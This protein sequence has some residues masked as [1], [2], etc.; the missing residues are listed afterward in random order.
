MNKEETLLREFWERNI[1]YGYGVNYQEFRDLCMR[2]RNLASRYGIKL[3]LLDSA[4]LITQF[5]IAA[6]SW[7][8]EY[9]MDAVEEYLSFIYEEKTALENLKELLEKGNIQDVKNR[10]E[11]LSK[12]VQLLLAKASRHG[13]FLGTVREQILRLHRELEEIKEITASLSKR[14]I[15]I[16]EELLKP[17]CPKCGSEDYEILD[18]IYFKESTS[19]ALRCKRCGYKYAWQVPR[20]YELHQS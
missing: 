6:G 19:Y 9:I 12:E 7:Q 18:V 8:P 4:K 17:I 10:I 20:G 3:S 14:P 16:Y 11:A 2:V 13:F 5:L 15:D 1:F